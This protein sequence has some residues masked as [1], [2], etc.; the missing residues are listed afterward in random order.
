MKNITLIIKDP[1]VAIKLTKVQAEFFGIDISQDIVHGELYTQGFWQIPLSF[2]ALAI[3]R[4]YGKTT[5]GM[6]KIDQVEIIGKRTLSNV[7]QGGYDLTGQVSFK[8]KKHAA[9]TSSI[10]IEVEGK[11]IDCSCISI[12]NKN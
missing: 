9:V 12:I 6:T 1:D 8:G 4:T 11:L 7:R 5:Y 10:M 2:K 3:K